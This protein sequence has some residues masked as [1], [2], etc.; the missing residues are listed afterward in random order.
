MHTAPRGEWEQL[1]FH[2]MGLNESGQDPPSSEI[3]DGSPADDAGSAGNVGVRVVWRELASRIISDYYDLTWF[4]NTTKS[5]I[6]DQLPP[7]VS[8]GYG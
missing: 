4:R 8:S 3:A 1:S 7:G 6:N 5:K 2:I